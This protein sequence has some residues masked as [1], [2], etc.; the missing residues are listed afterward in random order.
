M[1]DTPNPLPCGNRLEDLLDQVAEAAAPENP[2]HQSSCPYC[3]TALRHLRG[4]WADLTELAN[5]PVSVP[6]G[7]T[8]QIMTR[9]RALAAQAADHL[10]LGHPRGD[11]LISHAVVGRI[12]Q[13]LAH[14]V[15]GVNFASARVE[16]L[17]PPRTDRL[18]LSIHLIVTLG[19]RLP[20][21]ANSVRETVRRHSL[22]LTGARVDRIDITIDDITVSS[23]KRLQ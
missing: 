4:G 2:E 22:Q 9:V 1:T 17:N 8:A 16:P 20:R 12:V 18:D 7:L 3:Q 5:E 6:G 13:R 23:S 14:T 11:T 21:L 10:L 15:P 19:P